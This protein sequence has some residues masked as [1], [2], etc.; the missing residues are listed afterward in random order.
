M[1]ALILACLLLATMLAPMTLG[2]QP[3]PGPVVTGF[4]VEGNL[5]VEAEAV[6]RESGVMVGDAIDPRMLGDAIRQI[7]ALD[8]FEDIQI[9]ARAVGDGITL[10]FLVTEKPSVSA[11]EYRGNDKIDDDELSEEIGLRI[12]SILDESRVREG[13]AQIADLY[14][15]K[16]YYLVE[17]TP[18]I[19]PSGPGTVSV[20]Y[21]VV[22]SQRVRVERVSIVGNEQIADRELQR[23]LFTRPGTLLSFLTQ[24]GRFKEQ[25]FENDLQRL[26]YAYYEEG[27]L[28]IVI[29]A[30][31]V[32][33]SRDLTGV[34]VTIPVVEGDVY[35]VSDVS[36]SGEMLL[37]QEEMMEQFVRTRPGGVFRSSSVRGDI[38]RITNHYR[39]AGYANANVNMLTRQDAESDTVGLQYDIEQG[40]LCYIGRIEV[41][42]NTLTRDKVI[43]R[44]LLI[45]EGDQYHGGDI[46]RS[47]GYV[48]RLGFFE[49][50]VLRE[51]P[52]RTNPRMIDIQ[53][54]VIERPTRSLQ[55]GAGFSSVDSFIATA[56]VRENNLF[57]RA[58][59]LTLNAQL[60]ALRTIFVLSFVE[61]YLFDSRVLLSVDLF[62]R[63]EVLPSFERQSQGF[64][65]GFG[66]R[67][68]WRHRFWRDLQFLWGYQLE[69]VS[70]SAGGRGGRDALSGPARRARGGLTSGVNGGIQ[71][72]TRTDRIVTTDGA[73]QSLNLEVADSVLGSE[74]EFYRLR[75]AS[76][77]YST[78]SFIECETDDDTLRLR[79]RSLSRGVCRW[80]SSWVGKLNLELG[81][82]GTTNPLKD[83]P[84]YER[85][86]VGGPT[87]VR[88]FERFTLSPTQPGAA[89]LSP[90]STLRDELIGG[91]RQ[92]FANVELEFPLVQVLGLRGVVFFD[93]GNAFE[94]DE[95]YTLNLDL[96]KGT[97][98]NVLRT[99]LGWGFRW[100]SP[101]GPLRFEW[102]YPLVRAPGERRVVFEF[103]IQNAF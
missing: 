23:S 96:W 65:L 80:L 32:E 26:R 87:S 38:E 54:E 12:D 15:E 60:S 88:G 84:I 20:T 66:Y 45:E 74:N 71:F 75:A 16:G 92:F 99:A 58:Q 63:E 27:Y 36:V 89:I 14:R 4:A 85:F 97:E 53:I 101:I 39:D 93:A 55:V 31:T 13:A 98:G 41:I 95:P 11:I 2:A 76:R 91:H 21:D 22:E 5:R 64:G 62:R 37:T 52:S 3:A 51:I 70:I 24:T 94:A 48:R 102:G 25:E 61:P 7:Y 6:I 83:V 30:P 81:L 57:G 56:E 33:L 77:W 17:V 44:E 78:P 69:D 67:P 43:R 29:G 18:V 50:V 40:E 42:G 46:D 86:F 82:V 49:D 73:F 8:W 10:V 19:E 35:S 28:D 9:D 59:S 100:R 47:A 90:E 103:S 68:F 34:Y 79:R 72:D 1:R